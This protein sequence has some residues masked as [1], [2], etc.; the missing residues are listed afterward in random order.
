MYVIDMGGNRLEVFKKV[1]I[2]NNNKA[3]IV[4][5][6]GNFEGNNLWNATQMCANFA[7]RTLTYQGFTKETIHYL[8]SDTDL[9]LDNNGAPDDVDGDATNANMQQAITQ[10]AADADSLVVYLVDHGG[11]GTF[12]MSGS[13]VLPASDL[14]F[15]LDQLQATLP[16]KVTIIYDAC[17]SGSFISQLTPPEGKQRIVVGS[18]S[19]G[20]S[21][22]FV[23]QGSI[24]FSSF[25]W[26]HIFNGLNVKESFT[27]AKD[28]ISDAIAFQH[29]LLDDSGNGVGNEAEDGALAQNTFIGNGTVIYGD[30]PVIG[31]VSPDKTINDTNSTSLFVF[32]ITDDD[33]IAR[34]WAV[35]RPPNY[36]QGSTY[37]P[38]YELPSLDLMPTTE[39]KWE[40]TWDNFNIPGTY[41]IAI[42]AR[43]RIGNTSV[44][45][46]TTVSVNNPLTRKALIVAASWQADQMWAS[47]QKNAVMAYNV[48]KFQG[49]TEDDIYVMCNQ[50]IPGVVIDGSSTAAN[51]ND[52][53][54]NWA[55]DGA[56]DLVLYMVANG[57][58]KSLR[59][60][61]TES[62]SSETLDALL[63]NLQNTIPGAITVIYDACRAGSF[64]PDL[65]P[66]PEK[67]R[68]I[69]TSTADNSPAYF[70]LNGDISF[71]M[72]F[73]QQIINGTNIRDAYLHCK[74]AIEFAT[75]SAPG[76]HIIAQMDDNGNGI[77]NEKTDKL[78]AF[79]TRIGTG[80]MLAGDA[81]LTGSISP[82]TTL[83]GETS[84]VIRA[85]NVTTTG[86]LQKVW[87]VITPPG[88]IQ[89]PETP[90]TDLPVVELLPVG[91]NRFE[92]TY[93][94]FMLL[95]IYEISVFAIDKNGNLSSP[96]TTRFTQTT[97]GPDSYEEDDDSEQ[98]KVI[99]I[100]DT[101]P[102][103]HN[104]DV[105]GDEDW[106]KFYGISGEHYTIQVD[107]PG[108][109]CDAVIEVRDTKNNP[110]LPPRD[111]QGP[112]E[113]EMLDWTCPKD[114]IYYVM[115]RNNDSAIFGE[116]SQYELKV[117][118]PIMFS[119]LI[120]GMIT[121]A[122]TEQ[123]IAG[124]II[125]TTSGA[126]A[127]S[128]PNGAY[129]M[130][131]SP[132]TFTLTAE[133]SGFKMATENNVTIK[134]GE[135]KT[136]HFQLFTDVEGDVNN[137]GDTDLADAVS[138]L[139]IIAGEPL[140]NINSEA[141]L[142]GDHKIGLE[143]VVYILQ[144]V[145]DLR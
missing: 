55:K 45:V 1:Q 40:G 145:S 50:E 71:S 115:V 118:R 62:V 31:N 68:I 3:I 25:F 7:Y 64:I 80:I 6:G 96:K 83:N 137:S 53:L 90:L 4:S 39:G 22:Y 23:T 5:G 129:L 11:D 77:A 20:E 123:I 58:Q 125:K 34:V 112:G 35:I 56:Q 15:W 98:A 63:D 79:D 103:N 117:Y 28:S 92:G 18:T 100:N 111:D 114:G 37:N 51:L 84:A 128:K 113:P 10:W 85:E 140:L 74:W 141:D 32:F 17:E 91:D 36:T 66:P 109:N 105:S 130:A 72:F 107:N 86:E 16:G 41:H 104:F 60:N 67:K 46:M 136:K 88:Y 138:A 27:L 93:D 48:L 54:T 9:D 78:L 73:W 89:N 144:E 127:I 29:P 143:E 139:Q 133:A 87:A 49:Y 134:D 120:A 142:D 101:S 19:P 47:V 65:L 61:Q 135:V 102:Q 95:G 99:V 44:P 110:V 132:G 76:G 97:V 70:A 59:I 75:Q 14:D 94:G 21:A 124:A 43:D 12:R 108:A 24:S 30:I 26:T 52:V 82:E 126:S 42:Y 116:N 57:N 106:V 38:V 131:P 69:I 13:E 33:E 81:P 121:Q 122:C 2:S 119:G 8:T